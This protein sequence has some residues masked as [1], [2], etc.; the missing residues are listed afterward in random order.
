MAHFCKKL[1]TS[2]SDFFK[3]L[4][5]QCISET[6]PLRLQGIHSQQ[7]LPFRTHTVQ[8]WMWRKQV[9][10]NSYSTS[11][12]PNF[13]GTSDWFGERQFFHGH[14]GWGGVGWSKCIMLTKPSWIWQEVE[15]RQQCQKRGVAVNTNEASLTHSL[16]TSCCAAWLLTGHRRVSV[17]GPGAGDPCT[18]SKTQASNS[19]NLHI[20]HRAKCFLTVQKQKPIWL[21]DH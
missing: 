18:K 9:L 10:W 5:K 12:V 16:L 19:R 11:A 20:N 8:T 7:Q 17:R 2:I 15:L 4:Q 21:T 13:F 1:L 14:R 6:E 3:S